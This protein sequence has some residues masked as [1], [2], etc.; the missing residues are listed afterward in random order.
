[1]A[2]SSKPIIYKGISGDFEMFS[3][4]ISEYISYS[5]K[6]PFSCKDSKFVPMCKKFYF[7]FSD[8]ILCKYLK[9]F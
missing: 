5:L 2:K 6:G 8:C 7:K 3:N 1:M 9:V 4:Y